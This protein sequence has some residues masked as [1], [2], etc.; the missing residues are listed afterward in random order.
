VANG[1]GWDLHK[2]VRSSLRAESLLRLPTRRLRGNEPVCMRKRSRECR[3]LWSDCIAAAL[4]GPR[5]RLLPSGGREC[6]DV[7]GALARGNR[8]LCA[9]LQDRLTTLSACS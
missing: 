5:H 3:L 9:D 1:R 7:F 4:R 8:D 6:G 2:C